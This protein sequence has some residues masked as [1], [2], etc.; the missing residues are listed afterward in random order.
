MSLALPAAVLLLLVLPGFLAVQGFLGRIGRKSVDPVGQAGLTWTWIIAL[1]IA[2]ALHA[3]WCNFL[4]PLFSSDHAD[5]GAT[6]AVLSG[7]SPEKAGW[8]E[9]KSA[10]IGKG[11]NIFWYFFSIYAGSALIG[12]AVRRIVRGLRL[13]IFFRLFRFANPW[14]YLFSGEQR[15]I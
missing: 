9:V 1:P 12:I 3:I 10:V 11:G 7:V 6:L 8:A 13:D 4:V 14:E 5:L 15:L 2:A